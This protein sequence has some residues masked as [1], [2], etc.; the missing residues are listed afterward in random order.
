ML[1]NENININKAD[2]DGNTPLII[3]SYHGRIEIIKYIIDS[4]REINLNAKKT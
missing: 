2:N 1:K 3:A 4:G